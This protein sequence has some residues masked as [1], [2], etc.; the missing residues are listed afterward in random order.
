MDATA[1][2]HPQDG[3]WRPLRCSI[4]PRRDELWLKPTGELD[5]ES[6]GVLR[7]V[8]GEYLDAH[9]PRLVL[10]LRA[11]TF[12]DS[13]GLHLLLEAQREARARGVE[14]LVSPGPPSV[15]RVFDVTGTAELFPAPAR[16]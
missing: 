14:L 7:A 16:R 10:D 9:F 13:S 2:E 6:A 3:R 5:L 11:I 1:L 8:V 4:E 12:M 15:Q